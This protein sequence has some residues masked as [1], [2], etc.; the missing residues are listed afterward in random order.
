MQIRYEIKTDSNPMNPRKEFDNV[1]EM[2]C[3]HS[4]YTLGDEHSFSNP[5]DVIQ[6]LLSEVTDEEIEQASNSKIGVLE[7]R[8]F[9]ILPLYLYDH[10]G[11]TM[12]VEPFS[13][14]WD[15]GQVGWIYA[16]PEKIQDEWNGDK[17]KAENYLRGEVK[18]YDQY[19]T[20]EVYG[21]IIETRE[22]DEDEWEEHD[23]CWGYFG[24]QYCEDEVKSIVKGMVGDKITD[25]SIINV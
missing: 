25:G 8:G 5:D 20:D 10:S 1:G 12:S 9:V 21:Y 15:S 4:R 16:T 17:T 18:T 11:I 22:T 19:L 6:S 14:P 7:N 13:C 2:I 23:S 3:F 24:H